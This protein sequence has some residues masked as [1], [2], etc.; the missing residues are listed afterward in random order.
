[1]REA[2]VRGEGSVRPGRPPLPSAENFVGRKALQM[3]VGFPVRC[4]RES[5]PRLP[6]AG[7]EIVSED[8][9]TVGMGP[10][11]HSFWQCDLGQR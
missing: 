7:K 4:G 10:G 5:R 6:W 8:T 2:E 3:S 11:G 9:V 1:M